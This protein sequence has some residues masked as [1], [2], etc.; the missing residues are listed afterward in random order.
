[1]PA[2]SAQEVQGAVPIAAWSLFQDAQVAA[3]AHPSQD[4]AGGRESMQLVPIV[5]AVRADM[6]ASA[7]GLPE[8]HHALPATW[9]ARPAA[10][11][12][13]RGPAFGIAGTPALRA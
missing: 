11:S 5:M 7:H 6:P 8:N 9:H 4:R 13:H 12:G 3:V 10:P 1:M 2:V